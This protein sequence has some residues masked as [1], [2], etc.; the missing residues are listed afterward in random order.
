MACSTFT[1][2]PPVYYFSFYR[3]GCFLLPLPFLM[4][5]RSFLHNMLVRKLTA[6]PNAANITVCHNCP[7]V[8]CKSITRPV[9]PKVPAAMD[10]VPL[11]WW[12]IF[13]VFGTICCGGGLAY[14]G[15]YCPCQC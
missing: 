1:G 14:R 15:G 4:M 7:C 2:M 3:W 8:T 11:F 9:P 10:A 13:F 5:P 12:S 6:A